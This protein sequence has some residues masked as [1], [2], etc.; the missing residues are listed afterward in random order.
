MLAFSN[1]GL[2]LCV[3]I[4]W[5]AIL[6]LMAGFHVQEL[7]LCCLMTLF[8]AMLAEAMQYSRILWYNVIIFCLCTMLP[9]IFY[10][11]SYQEVRI[12]LFFLGATE[13][14][15]LCSLLAVFFHRAVKDRMQRL[16][17]SWMTSLM[18][19]SSGKGAGTFSK[20]ITNMPEG[21]RNLPEIVQKQLTQM[22][23]L[24]CCRILLPD[25]YLTG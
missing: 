2:A 10:Y 17:H 20:R 23:G 16:Q 11:L 25:R 13:G 15:F 19:L 22:K 6:A 24:P 21:Y 14:A 12:S 8:G 7:V 5:D 9:G 3:G 4:F 1:Q 18:P